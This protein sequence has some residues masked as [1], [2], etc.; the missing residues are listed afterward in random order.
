MRTLPR[1][2]SRV[3]LVAVTLFAACSSPADEPAS[4]RP[5]L[6]EGRYGLFV[7]THDYGEPGV[8]VSGQ[9]AVWEGRQ[10][11]D[12]LHALALPDMAWL[13]SGVPGLG[14]C[15]AVAAPRTPVVDGTEAHIELLGVGELTVEAPVEAPAVDGILRL[16]PRDFPRVLFSLGGVVYDADAPQA[17]PY[18]A[19][20]TYRVSAPGDELG[21][22]IAEIAAPGE[23]RLEH[24]RFDAAGLEVRW[25]GHGVAVL[26]LS[27]ESGGE[28]RG[29]QC[30]APGGASFVV[31]AGLLADFG[32][33]DAQLSVGE[34]TRRRVRVAGLSAMDLFFV[35]R[36]QAVVRL[37]AGLAHE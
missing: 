35:S 16:Q 26:T 18:V 24:S 9:F 3:S 2:F 36:D 28:T 19:Q 34:I 11:D 10:R 7:M 6:G 4:P 1:M 30:H 20:G 8:A 13:V 12:V 33:G 37:P 21:P 15:R 25:S 27:R 14:Q 31:P 22:V 23:V 17:L 29:V 32:G 5:A